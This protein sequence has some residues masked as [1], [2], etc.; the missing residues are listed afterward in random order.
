MN[1]TLMPPGRPQGPPLGEAQW[2]EPPWSEPQWDERQWDE[3]Q[4]NGPEREGPEL[5]GPPREGPG[6]AGPGESSALDEARPPRPPRV[7][8]RFRR[9]WAEARRAEGRRRLRVVLGVVGLLCLVGAGIGALYSPLFALRHV[10]VRG[11]AHTPRSQVLAAAG[12]RPGKTLMVKAGGERAVRAVDALPWV[13]DVSFRRRWPWSLVVTVQER[14]PAALVKVGSQTSD[15]VDP[16]G[17]VLEEVKGSGVPVLPV[18]SGATGAA[19]GGYLSPAAPVTSGQLDELL[20]AAAATPG[21]LAKRDIGFS[22][23]AADGLVARMSGT[24]ATVVLG[25]A[26][27]LPYKLGVLAELAS[28]VQLSQ[29]SLVGLTVPESPALTPAAG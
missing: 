23:S 10:E 28:R 19:P 9:R 11:D 25:D 29:Y 5:G 12:I 26:T 2:T 3:R 1:E 8:P 16:S 14:S 21:V 4:W 27:D 15:V 17:R 24:T 20:A 18:I 7:D 13:R 22:Y 6:R